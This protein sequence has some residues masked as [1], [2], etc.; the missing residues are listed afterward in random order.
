MSGQVN[1]A[2][3]RRNGN[4]VMIDPA[5]IVVDLHYNVRDAF[6]VADPLDAELYHSILA[7]GF[8]ADKPVVIRIVGTAAHL[9]AGHRRH[10]AVMLARENGAVIKEVACIL[11]GPGASGKPRDDAERM[12]D[13]VVSNS[14]KPLSAPEKATVILRLRKMGWKDVQ[15]AQRLGFTSDKWVRELVKVTTLD[16]RLRALVKA[17]VIAPTLAVEM[18]AEHGPEKAAD[19]AEAAKKTAPKTGAKAGKVTGAVVALVTG[20]AAKNAKTAPAPVPPVKVIPPRVE[21]VR[22][23]TVTPTATLA[24]P[25]TI[26]T[27]MDDCMLFDATG[28]ELCEFADVA[29]AKA[30]LLLINQGWHV[31]K[32]KSTAT[33]PEPVKAV[34]GKV[35]APKGKPVTPTAPVQPVPGK[36]GVTKE[37]ATIGDVI[38]ARKAEQAAT[39]RLVAKK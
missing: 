16:P 38:A 36:P 10:A 2:G 35:T 14:G 24:G 19:I 29:I 3:M 12:A 4:V 15:I 11:E 30:I 21:P 37:L 9:V 23:G 7:N 17:N 5:K 6:D 20:K 31:F 22:S 27:D 26:G 8:Q 33:T 25:F 13:L 28:T 32:G 18:T 1:I 39:G 34:P